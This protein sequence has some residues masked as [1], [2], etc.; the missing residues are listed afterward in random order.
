MDT[1]SLTTLTLAGLAR[2]GEGRLVGDDRVV[3]FHLDDSRSLPAGALFVALRG[4]RFDGHEFAARRCGPGRCGLLVERPLP[5]AL[6]QV[7]VP[8]TLRALT[9]CARAQRR[10]FRGPGGRRD[11][12]Q[13]QDNDQGND[14]RDPEPERA[15]A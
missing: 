4:E 5:I 12:Q 8:D 10:R 15:P 13:R 7:V 9:A 6:P 2:C 14:R 1:D 11:R 3:R